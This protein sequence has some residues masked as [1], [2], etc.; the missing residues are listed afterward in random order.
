MLVQD[1]VWQGVDVE[2]LAVGQASVWHREYLSVGASWGREPY[3][4]EEEH[5]W[6]NWWGNP[7][8]AIVTIIY[9]DGLTF[10]KYR[11]V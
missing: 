10:R 9:M 6:G 2:K 4:L 3:K 1:E 7:I 5:W 8:N 11:Q